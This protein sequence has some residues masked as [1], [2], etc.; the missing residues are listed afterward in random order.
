MV[1]P[2]RTIGL[3][4]KPALAASIMAANGTIKRSGGQ[5]EKTE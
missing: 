1:L 4:A 2:S 3:A 5:I